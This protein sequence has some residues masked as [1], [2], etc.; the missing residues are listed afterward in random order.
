MSPEL[1]HDTRFKGDVC[2]AAF[3]GESKRKAR[4]ELRKVLRN[5]LDLAV[6]DQ[7]VARELRDR[8]ADLRHEGVEPFHWPVEFPEV[9]G[10][11]N[12]GFDSMVGNPPFMGKN[13]LAAGSHPNYLD[14]L[15]QIHEGSHGNSDIVAHFFRRAFDL[16]RDEGTF[17]LIATNTIGQGDT[18]TTGLQHLCTHGASIYNADKRYVWPGMAAVIVS[19]IHVFKGDYDAQ[20]YLDHRP[21]DDI[22]AFLFHAG[23]HLDPHQLKANENKAFVGSYVLGMGFTF[24]DTDTKGVASSLAD[25]ERLIDKDHRNAERIFPYIGGSEVNS[26]PTHSHHRYVINFGEMSEE[27]ARDWPD[28]MAIVEER[29]K[30]ERLAQ[31]DATPRKK[32]WQFS[33]LRPELINAL[34]SKKQ[35]LVIGCGA[36]KY[37]AFAVLPSDIVFAHVLIVFPMNNLMHNYSVMQSSVHDLWSRFFSSSM[38]DDIRYTPSSCFETFPFPPDWEDNALLEEVGQFYYDYRAQLMIE[39]DEGMTT[40]YNRFHDPEE[41]DEGIVKLRELHG[42][43]D[44]AVLAAYGWDDVDATCEFLLDYEIDEETW[45]NKKKPYRYRWPDTV[46]DEVLARLLDLNQQRHE[47]EEAEAKKLAAAEKRAKKKAK[48]DSKSGKSTASKTKS[49][50]QT[51]LI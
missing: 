4:D 30:P 44:R 35:V 27:E 22:T 10:R 3:F 15:K 13:T 12:A 28:L 7:D 9:F 34:E 50:E 5:N 38:K 33:R 26:S 19:V 21:V 45:G 11:P 1:L 49:D 47:E 42:D 51:E 8:V 14:W 40:T 20:R 41:H 25:M 6:H 46:H 39:N 32:W 18:R 16:I 23:G 36:T 31:K 37:I 48:A 2:V 43:M 17:G 24:D 29:V